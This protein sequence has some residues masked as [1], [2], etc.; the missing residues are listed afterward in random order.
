MRLWWASLSFQHLYW[1]EKRNTWLSQLS[2]DLWLNLPSPRPCCLFVPTDR[3]TGRHL[4]RQAVKDEG[5][6]SLCHTGTHMRM[7]DK[8]PRH[9]NYMMCGQRVREIT[10]C[11][12]TQTALTLSLLPALAGEVPFPTSGTVCNCRWRFQATTKALYWPQTN[13]LPFVLRWLWLLGKQ[14]VNQEVANDSARDFHLRWVN[15]WMKMCFG[16]TKTKS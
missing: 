6:G 12:M 5:W 14:M 16:Q 1:T 13:V 4:G 2:V 7:A 11:R 8:Q 3:Q 9:A 10:C 15:E